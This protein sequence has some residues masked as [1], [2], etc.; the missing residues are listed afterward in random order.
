M[1]YFPWP[2]YVTVDSSLHL[3][4]AISNCSSLS[5]QGNPV[6]PLTQP[7][8]YTQEFKHCEYSTMEFSCWDHTQDLIFHCYNIT[9]VKLAESLRFCCWVPNCI[10]VI[11]HLILPLY[12]LIWQKENQTRGDKL[13]TL[14]SENTKCNLSPSESKL[15]L[16]SVGALRN[17]GDSIG[18]FKKCVYSSR[19]V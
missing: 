4:A 6:F 18:F 2:E 17:W 8:S 5:S 12:C 7:I 1:A 11:S 10:K 19:K 14:K 16:T 3:G 15:A 13:L 9:Q